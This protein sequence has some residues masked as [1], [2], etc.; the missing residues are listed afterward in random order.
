MYIDQFK[1]F[2]DLAE[3]ESFSKAAALSGISQSAV[4]QQVR[5]LELKFEVTLVER[6]RRNFALT[7]EGLALLD[8]SR[9]ILAIF[10]GLGST[11][12]SLRDVVGGQLRI[13]SIYSI[14]L[15][16]LPPHLKRFRERHPDVEVHVEY[17][18]SAQVYQQVLDGDVDL[19]LVAYPVKRT[20]LLVEVFD[21][22]TMVLISAPAH[23]LAKET[24]VP[25]KKLRGE[26][27]IAFE[28]DQP[29]RKVIDRYLR[30]NDIEVA[31]VMEF[32]NIETVK[33][34]VEIES[35]ISIVPANTVRQEV[36]LG[37]LAQLDLGGPPLRRTLGVIAKR[38][39]T[40]SPAQAEFLS[41]LRSPARIASPI[42][43]ASE[44]LKSATL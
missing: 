35:G 34:A 26:R 13:A 25:L 42:R 39:R 41:I 38:N 17:R 19:G 8:A 22:D 16:E 21:E 2:S 30:E 32:D 28:P 1:V 4:S 12:R 10:N 15:H 18:R 33:R 29:T 36:A 31:S 14:G 43:P 5:A 7:P 23:A 37:A 6:G 11:L 44:P 20:G 24:H 9:Q 27:F 3:T 40:C